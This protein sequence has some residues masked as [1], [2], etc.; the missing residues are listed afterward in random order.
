MS[1]SAT[2]VIFQ[3]FRLAALVG[4]AVLVWQPDSQAQQAGKAPQALVLQRGTEL[5]EVWRPDQHLYV[6][7]N[8]GVDATRLAQLQTWLAANGPHWTVLLMD[9]AQGE[10][11]RDDDGHNHSGASAVEFAV[12]RGLP[13]LGG[14]AARKDPRTGQGDGAALVILLKER[15]FYYSGSETQDRRGLG[16]EHW[17]GDLDRPAFRAMSNGRRLV[18]AVEATVKEVNTRLARRLQ[19]EQRER[20]RQMRQAQQRLDQAARIVGELA[21]DLASLGREVAAF[22]TKFPQAAQGDLARFDLALLNDSL[23]A[24]ES[25]LAAGAPGEALQRASPVTEFVAAQRSALV[26]YEAAPAEFEALNAEIGNVKPGREGWGADRL[27]LAVQELEAAQAAH[28]RGEGAYLGHLENARGSLRSAHEELR[29]A[30]AELRAEIARDEAIRQEAQRARERAWRVAKTAAGALAL[31]LIGLA[32]FLNRRRRVFRQEGEKLIATWE[33]GFE[34]KTDELFAL[35]DRTTVVVGSAIDLPKRGYTG[36]TSRLGKQTIEDVDQLFIMSS[37]VA[38]LLGE[39]RLQVFPKYGFQRVYNWFGTARYR[40]A[41]RGLRDDLIT[42][43]PE[44]GIELLSRDVMRSGKP[45]SLLGKL[46]SYQPFALSFPKL[47]EEFDRRAQRATAALDL[48]ENSWASIS[49]DLE[50]VRQ[51]VDQTCRFEDEILLEARGSDRL[52]LL[53]NVFSQLLPSAQADLDAAVVQGETDPVGALAEPL[54]EA[55]RKAGDAAA[56]CE[57][58]LE[59]RRVRFPA[60]REEMR[61]L[62]AAGHGTRWV[63]NFLTELSHR[64]EEIAAQATRSPVADEQQLLADQLEKLERRCVR[65]RELAARLAETAGK[66]IDAVRDAVRTARE[67]IGTALELAQDLVLR[68]GGLDPDVLLREADELQVAASLAIDRGGVDAAAAALDEVA[69]LMKQGIDLVAM[70]R[71]SFVGHATESE[72]RDAETRALA[73]G[74]GRHRA[75]LDSLIS[76]YEASALELSAGD[77][78]HPTPGVSIT[79]HIAKAER[80]LAEA[81]E[82]HDDAQAAYREARLIEASSLLAYI[83]DL[84]HRVAALFEEIREREERIAKR[85]Q[86]NAQALRQLDD[87]AAAMASGVADHRTM[88]ATIDAF[89]EARR[90]LESA[91]MRVAMTPGDPFNA[92]DLLEQVKRKLA[93]VRNMAASDRDLFDELTRSLQEAASYLSKAKDVSRRSADDQ[94]PDSR[95]ISELQEEVEKLILAK[96]RCERGLK[97]AHGDWVALDRDADEIAAQAARSTAEM[98]GELETAEAAVAAIR[99]AAASV[100][101]AGSWVGSYGVRIAGSPGAN[102]LHEA[103]AAL[104]NGR[105][106]KANRY[107]DDAGRAARQSISAARNEE[108]RKRRAAAQQAAAARRRSSFASSSSSSSGSSFSFGGGGSSSGGG[109]FGG[110]SG[111]SSSGMGGSSFSSGGSGM[112]SSGW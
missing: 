35:L 40:R 44:D 53:E 108:D 60:M 23:K 86:S 8:V 102:R 48:I 21:A 103:R 80:D 90:E 111:S 17:N 67:E 25:S 5:L 69:A 70:T 24:A 10:V 74:V 28:R 11:Y 84:Q 57:L 15:K 12:G 18:D 76:S 92:G 3:T 91:R 13:K 73:E 89:D 33:S 65:A 78:S 22:K 98:R 101:E 2:R 83:G 34:D 96:A 26:S 105:Y 16:G 49:S 55:R 72:K 50:A 59:T 4:L 7:G 14:F 6:K 45:E 75:I 82:R 19:S 30:A 54:P 87:E 106:L 37:T 97:E 62:E 29:R 36:E 112:G 27:E 32:I 63:G 107:A 88:Q 99:A 77:P 38:R 52:F 41:M 81:R 71:A 104:M 95:R 61:K 94:I 58:V 46:E 20:E 110:S 9:H 66:E 64:A 93:V 42:F 47:I 31:A 68:E 56:L 43:S 51:S 79:D 85:E 1:C 39:A 100:R 109:S